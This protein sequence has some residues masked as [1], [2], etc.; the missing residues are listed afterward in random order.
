VV[1]KTGSTSRLHPNRIKN[2]ACGQSYL[3]QDASVVG[4]NCQMIPDSVFAKLAQH[5][6]RPTPA[7]HAREG[8]GLGLYEKFI[9]LRGGE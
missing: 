3:A 8:E 6:L 7:P 5:Q 9:S 2:L 1:R 4:V